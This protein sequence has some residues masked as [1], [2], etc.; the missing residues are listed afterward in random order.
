[1]NPGTYTVGPIGV[2]RSPRAVPQY[3]GWGPIS[4]EIHLDEGLFTPDA[5]AG[6]SDFSHLEVVFHFH[7]V[8]EAGVLTGAAPPRGRADLPPVGVLAQ[9]I[10]ERP[11][12]LAV[13]RCELALV[14][15][16]VL[17][18]R[19][20]DALDGT[21]VLDVKPYLSRFV[22]EPA[23]VREPDWIKEVMRAYY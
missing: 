21:P 16:L 23:A 4:A 6:L 10:K 7:L 19:A 12:R 20:L 5:V 3:D 17:H 15:G 14:N 22:P 11:N 13:S 9:R 8:D 1:M 18:V 2:V